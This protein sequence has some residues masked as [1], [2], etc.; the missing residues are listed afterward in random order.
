[1]I[2]LKIVL[3]E[4]PSRRLSVICEA[5]NFI[6]THDERHHLDEIMGFVTRYQENHIAEECPPVIPPHQET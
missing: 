2:V 5:E 1:M 4:D 6:P 3:N